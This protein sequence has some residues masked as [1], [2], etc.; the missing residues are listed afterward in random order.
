MDLKGILKV[1]FLGRGDLWGS[2][3]RGRGRREIK[4]R[5]FGKNVF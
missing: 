4:L 3:L 1:G 5:F 2:K